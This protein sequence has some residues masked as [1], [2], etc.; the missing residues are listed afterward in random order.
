MKSILSSPRISNS[1]GCCHFRSLISIN[2]SEIIIKGLV[3]TRKKMFQYG[4]GL[5]SE[6]LCWNP[7]WQVQGFLIPRVIIS[8]HLSLSILMEW[9]NDYVHYK[10]RIVLIRTRSFKIL[11][12]SGFSIPRMVIPRIVISDHSFIFFGSERI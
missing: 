4:H 7:N 2:P 12:I 11:N 9:E 5:K 8:D 3:I 10:K 1:K 6:V